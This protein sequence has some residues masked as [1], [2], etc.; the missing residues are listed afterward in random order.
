MQTLKKARIYQK[1]GNDLFLIDEFLGE[2]E[3]VEIQARERA[4]NNT[5]YVVLLFTY[6]LADAT[7]VT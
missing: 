3:P 5:D 7:L 1:I 2:P 4:T 6:E